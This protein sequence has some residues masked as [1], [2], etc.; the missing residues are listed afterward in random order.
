VLLLGYG[1]LVAF[2][3]AYAMVIV[4]TPAYIGAISARLLI[5]LLAIGVLGYWWLFQ[6]REALGAGR[7][8]LLVHPLF[9]ELVLV[10]IA[11]T[12]VVEAA[13]QWWAVAWAVLALLL[14]SPL[15]QRVLDARARLYSLL[16]YWVSVADMAAVMST[17]EVPSPHW[18]DQPEFT[19]LVAIVLQV[20]YVAW[21]HRR[22]VLADVAAPAPMRWLG[23][24]GARV[25]RRRNL[26]VHYPLFAGVAVFLYWRFD[27][28]LLTLLWAAE[29]FVVFV[30]SALL[31]E[32]QFRYVALAGLAACLARLVLIDMAQANLGMRGA[33]FIGVGSLMLGMNAIYNRYRTRFAQ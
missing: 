7:P 27:R 11:V 3:V 30:L 9:V 1:Y 25:D 26:Y 10:A 16:F 2:A 5:E 28:S 19:S 8:W 20:A 22:L 15:A 12:V 32:N 13:A 29:A 21:A 33:V 23:R 17:L 4:Q 6:P 31:R 14:L 18:Y 24:L